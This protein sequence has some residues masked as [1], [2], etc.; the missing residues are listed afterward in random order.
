M[1]DTLRGSMDAS[2]YKHIVLGLIFLK[3][4]S[5]AFEEMRA[6]LIAH[7][8][9]THAD[10]ENRDEYTAENI[11][12]VPQDA[13]W[14]VIQNAARRP[15]TNIGQIVD[16]AMIT[17]ERENPRVKDVLP[18]EYARPSLNQQQLGT[19]IDLISNIRV[20]DAAARSR[21]VLGRVY[22]YFLTQ[23]AG[24]EGG[25]AAANSTRRAASSNCSSAC[26]S[27]TG[28]ECM[29]RAADPPACSCSPS[30]SSKRTQAATAAAPSPACRQWTYPYTGRSLTT[31]HG[32]SPK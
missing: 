8:H 7:M 18:K 17:I 10:P 24:A 6:D 14:Q 19:L 31:P 2:E 3:Y 20:G 22:E 32:G 25:G 26:W 12:W 15:N 28:A 29:T 30:N 4:I 9:E 16:E 13:R 21:D 27:R 5:D 23:F 1:A 11:F